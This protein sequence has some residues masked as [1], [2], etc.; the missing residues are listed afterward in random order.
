[1]PRYALLLA[2][3][4]A[5]FAGFWRQAGRRSVGGE[6][7]AA[8]ERLGESGAAP[9][10]ASRTDAG[11][12]ARG[13]VAHVDLARDWQP[14]ALHRTLDHQLPADG[15]C[16]SVAP[17]ALAKTYRYT[18]EVAAQRDPLRSDRCWRPPGALDRDRLEQATHRVAATSDFAGFARRGDHR[19]D[20]R[21]PLDAIAWDERDGCL[22]ATLT[23][24]R[25]AY[26]LVRS[27]VGAMVAVANGRCDLAALD[28]SLAGE[29]G[30]AGA[31]QAPARGLC[32]EAIRYA[33]PP[34]WSPAVQPCSRRWRRAD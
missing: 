14:E 23:G 30:P 10:S 26:R 25:F 15:A 18:L 24:R 34:E 27:L 5:G 16:R 33:T 19:D 2:Y 1:M 17:V 31:Q 4:G 8:L 29:T 12:H 9:E 13:Q 28:R 32:L 7:D 11:V 20:W 6:L 22:V 21:C 3:H